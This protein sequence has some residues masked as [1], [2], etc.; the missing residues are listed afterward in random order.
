[1]CRRRQFSRWFRVSISPQSQ[2]S[3]SW[4]RCSRR[5]HGLDLA[6]VAGFRVL[7]SPRS[8]GS[9]SRRSRRFQGLDLAAVAGFMVSVSPHS[10]VS[11]SRSRRS[12]RFQGLDLAEVAGFRVSISL[13]SQVSGSIPDSHQVAMPRMVIFRGWCDPLVPFVDSCVSHGCS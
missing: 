3:G 1:M 11:G 10:Q 7:I 12:R 13:Q 4:S 2:V 6:A 8:S 9:R 5:F